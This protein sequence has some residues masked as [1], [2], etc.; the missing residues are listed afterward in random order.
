M[1]NLS[2]SET[3]SRR[4]RLRRHLWHSSW[5]VC[6][7]ASPERWSASSRRPSTTCSTLPFKPN[8]TLRGRM[9][10]RPRARVLGR[11]RLPE[12]LT[13]ENPLNWRTGSRRTKPSSLRV[14]NPTKVRP[15]LKIN[16]PVTLL[17][18]NVRERGTTRGIAQTN[19]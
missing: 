2:L 13:R 12:V 10:L 17:V 4:V 3:N 5:T 18:L 9:R 11:N 8:S 1:R 16:G 14:V 6:K 19:V 15:K 7:I